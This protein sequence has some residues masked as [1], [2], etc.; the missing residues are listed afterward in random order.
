M[1]R[2]STS[3]RIRLSNRAEVEIM[4]YKGDHALWHKHVH[5]VELDTVQVLKCIEMDDH[6]NTIDVSCRRTGKTAVK[7][8]HALKHN[9]TTPAQELGIVAPRLQQSQNNLNY[10]LEAIRRSPILKSRQLCTEFK[11]CTRL[12]LQLDGADPV[13]PVLYLLFLNCLLV[14]VAFL[15][16]IFR[17]SLRVDIYPESLLLRLLRFDT[18]HQVSCF[19]ATGAVVCRCKSQNIPS[20]RSSIHPLWRSPS[21]T[22]PHI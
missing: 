19:P 6:P 14:L 15:F 5:N 4:R 21:N 22:R 10:H 7:E 8:L 1:S 2:V 16:L 3:D 18:Q 17:F 12:H 20:G 9:A 11:L 13:L